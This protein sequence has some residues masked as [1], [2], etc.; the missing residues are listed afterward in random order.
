MHERRMNVHDAL[1]FLQE[2]RPE[3]SPNWG[4]LLQLVQL[5]AE[6]FNLPSPSL[7]LPGYTLLH[8]EQGNDA[9]ADASGDGN[10]DGDGGARDGAAFE[11]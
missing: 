2:R 9:I 4:F 5:E 6:L 1:Q 7:Q 8:E 11:S 10:E 3:V